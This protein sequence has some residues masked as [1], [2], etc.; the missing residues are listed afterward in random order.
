MEK[1]FYNK[2]L[3]KDRESLPAELTFSRVRGRI[4]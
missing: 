1:S 3:R 2:N 4:K